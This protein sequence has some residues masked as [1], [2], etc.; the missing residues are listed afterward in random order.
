MD[1]RTRAYLRGRFRDFYRKQPPPAPPAANRREWGYIPWTEGSATTMVRHKSLM[2]LGDPADFLARQRPRHVY[3]SAGRYRDPGAPTMGEKGWQGSDLVF[4]LD[5]D[6]LPAVD[7]E[8][9]SYASMLS[10]CKDALRRLL[11]FLTED[12]GF[13]DLQVVFSGG[14]GYHVHVRDERVRGLDREARR[15][16]VDYVRGIGVGFDDLVETAQRGPATARVL[17]TDGGWGRRTHRRLLAFADELAGLDDDDALDRL[18]AFDGIGEKTAETV[19][20]VVREDRSAL[21]DGAIERGGPAIRT[22][23]E[24]LLERATEQDSAAIDE[25]V[26]TD[27]HRL[28][29]LPGSLHGGTALEVTPVDRDALDGF[30]PLVD[31]VPAPFRGHEVTVRADGGPPVELGGETFTVPAGETRLPEYAANFL[32]AAGRAEKERE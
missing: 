16:I 6:H 17:A 30:D 29:R 26:T 8:A 9:D 15:E 22:L 21:R 2:E 14:R 19:L 3:F 31:A 4:D 27:T 1:E 25:P 10:A 20:Q 23:A 18:R 11:A 28:I 12:F 32:M 7:P 5:A 13:T 24:R